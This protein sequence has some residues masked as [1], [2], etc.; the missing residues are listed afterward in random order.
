MI[1]VAPTSFKGTHDAKAVAEAIAGAVAGEVLVRP[2][3]DGGPGLISAL[4]SAQRG[5]LHSVTVSG[6][7]GERACAR[8][9]VQRE[10]VVV[11]SADA[12]GMH[13]V[14]A[15]RLD[16]LNTTTF[17]VGE[18][19]LHAAQ[20]RK[21]IIIG[22]GGS[23]TVDCGLGM[24]RA[25]GIATDE[26]MSV[27]HLDLPP[28]T[29]LADV[30]NQ[31]VGE[32]GAARVFGPQK[33]ASPEQVEQLEKRLND[34]AGLIRRRLHVDVAH[35]EGA[36]AAGGLGAGLMAFAGANLVRGSEWVMRELGI[37]E[38]IRQCTLVIT[39]EGAYDAQSSMGK[40]TGALIERAVAARVPVLLIA[41]SIQGPL[42]PGVRVVTG[43]KNLSLD[44]IQSL[45][46]R[47]LPG[48][49][50]R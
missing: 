39:G 40:I 44:D 33:G 24:A 36:G 22:L 43:R 19:L 1:L 18:L 28:V 14:P 30:R 35:V 3:S 48:L 31:L 26:S 8:I 4:L 45:V 23:A 25:L 37:D 42:P 10:R 20:Y 38:L 9:L 41:G 11:E 21:P 29:A 6:P 16:P 50:A 49:L 32:N 5:E 27:A 7:L 12:C 13:L 46:R 15:D 34:A 2:I 17:G 47:T